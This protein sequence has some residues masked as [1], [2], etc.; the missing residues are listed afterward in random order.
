MVSG[1]KALHDIDRAIATARAQL[2]EAAKL[3]A[4]A[5]SALADISRKRA[6]AYGEIA[7][8]RLG[9]LERGST[10]EDLGYVDR[11][12]EK[13]L[14]AHAKEEQRAETKA[15]AARA[16]IAEL[17]E[18]R[19]AQ[20][21]HVAHAVDAY[22]KGATASQKKLEADPDYQALIE[23]AQK[24]GDMVERARAKYEMSVKDVEEKGAPYRNDPYFNYL[25]KRNYGTKDA[26]GW[27]LTKMLDGWIA[28]RGRKHGKGYREAV[29]NYRKLNDIPKRLA[30]HVKALE[31][32]ELDAHAALELAE[33]KMLKKEGVTALKTASL[34]EQKKL[35]ALDARLEK[36]E[37]KHQDLRAEQIKINAGDSASYRQAIE[38]LVNTLKRKDMPSLRRLAAQTVSRDD[39]RAIAQLV[40]LSSHADDLQEDQRVA[41]KL[42][43]KTQKNLDEM[44]RLRRKFKVHRFDA[45]SS[46]FPSRSMVGQ[47]L[48]QMVGG[49]ISS[50]DVWRQL[51]RAQ[52]TVRRRS[53]P[54]F[55]GVDWGEAMRLP[56]SSG[57][58][59]GS[60]GPFGGRSRGRT[61]RMPRMP[62]A[63]RPRAPR[64][65]LPRSGGFGGFG[66]GGGGGFHTKGGF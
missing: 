23:K 32:G 50:G 48:V 53:Q 29:L 17:E 42:V 12:A 25:R 1:R 36:A 46:E 7:K 52:R 40:A 9:L 8:L 65:R 54:D 31:Q 57:G 22:D 63:P 44:E 38:L 20:E 35:E 2:V 5:S 13:L 24:A 51:E 26:K 6:V 16:K 37:Q 47:L 64:I 3:P 4:R 58:W 33:Q 45:P 21:M 55:G 39:D 28:R 34:K 11:Q 41:R 49:L 14:K 43:D 15:E 66:G 61:T 10:A 19:R 56:R 18:L 62:R 60:S 27:F 30:G 59:G